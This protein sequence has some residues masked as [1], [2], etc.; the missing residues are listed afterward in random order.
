MTA[1]RFPREFHRRT[2]QTSLGPISLWNRPEV[3]GDV[4]PFLVLV[5]GALTPPE[6][7]PSW[8]REIDEMARVALVELPIREHDGFIKPN[9]ERL[10]DAVGQAIHSAYHRHPVLVVGLADSVLSLLHIRAPEV[11]TILAIEPPLITVKA[12]DFVGDLQRKFGVDESSAVRSY[13]LD[14]YGFNGNSIEPRDHR[15]AFRQ[16]QTPVDVVVSDI[17]YRQV[18]ISGSTGT[19]LDEVDKTWLAAEP[20]IK[21]KALS[22]DVSKTTVES[23]SAVW[24]TVIAAISNIV[25]IRRD[26]PGLARQI[27][28]AVPRNARSV[29]FRGPENCGF[30]AAYLSLNPSASCVL[31]PTA[32]ATFDLIVLLDPDALQTDWVALLGHL[33]AGGH[34][35]ATT[36][37][38]PA[39]DGLAARLATFGLSPVQDDAVITPT[40]SALVRARKGTPRPVTR[41]D[42][43][44]FARLLM[45]IRTTLPADSLRSD[46]SL[47]MNYCPP[48][49]RQDSVS[50]DPP[51]VV[52]VQRP[53]NG[54]AT[55]W[56]EVA[57]KSILARQVLVVEYDDHPD[58]VWQ[59]IKG[60]PPEPEAHERFRVAH[61]I[62]TSTDELID[63]FSLYNPEVKVFRNAVFDL[64]RFDKTPKPSR[65]FYGGVTRGSFAVEV[66]K[67]L[68]PAIEAHP[69]TEFYVLGDRAFFEALP[70]GRKVFSNYVPY[71]R[72]L[73]IMSQ[74]RVSLS[75]LQYR[76]MMETKSDA[77]Y[78]DASRAGVVTIASPT[79]YERTIRSG[80]NGFIARTLEDWPTMLAA[81]LADP[82]LCTRIALA[83]WNDVRANRMFA[84]QI[85]DRRDWYA[86]LLDRRESLDQAVLDRN[87]GVASHLAKLR[88]V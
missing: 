41:V 29:L 32:G 31:E 49:W 86:G 70:T 43:V 67:S 17:N 81:V 79:V 1:L 21:V 63:F 5:F 14:I 52:I 84:N 24:P 44:P 9:P 72:Y 16:S 47:Q 15:L 68:S 57:A 64:A 18:S 65:V 53:P 60:T 6:H 80:E 3:V 48:P 69:E 82:R 71:T 88:S 42:I 26:V 58:L 36:P 75:P 23:G 45:D 39:G 8:P 46:F 4:R 73:Q 74:C 62:Q 50:T 22:G 35:V 59:M 13:L 61:A 12:A 78:L 54:T 76:P 2:F 28:K 27:A 56:R 51:K 25:D 37:L 20:H 19:D 11:R 7:L 38:G 55:A 34:V 33:E 30:S 77:K 66:A 40:A 10:G 83:A 87:P 85:A